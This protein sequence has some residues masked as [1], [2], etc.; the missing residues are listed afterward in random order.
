MI[1]NREYQ[2]E[3]QLIDTF[4]VGRDL[5]RSDVPLTTIENQEKTKSMVLGEKSD[6]P[7]KIIGK[8]EKGKKADVGE[9]EKTNTLTAKVKNKEEL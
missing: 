2:K 8:E 6:I 9:L 3:T 7:S 5:E 4:D 1:F